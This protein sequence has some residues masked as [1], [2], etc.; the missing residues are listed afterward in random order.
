LKW[1]H[2]HSATVLCDN[3]SRQLLLKLFFDWRDGRITKSDGPVFF[4]P[5]SSLPAFRVRNPPTN[6]LYASRSIQSSDLNTNW[7]FLS[8]V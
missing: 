7:L 2:G 4:L 5:L 8:P 1:T 3:H 6:S